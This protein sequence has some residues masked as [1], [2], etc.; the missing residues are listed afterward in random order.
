MRQMFSRK[1]RERERREREE[2]EERGECVYKITSYIGKW[3]IRKHYHHL[4]EMKL[5]C[6]RRGLQAS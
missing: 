2:R 3:T 4:V 5:R 6:L 1:R